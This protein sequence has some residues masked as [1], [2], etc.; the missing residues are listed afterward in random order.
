MRV[1]KGYRGSVPCARRRFRL[2]F[3]VFHAYGDVPRAVQKR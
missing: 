3:V 1:E 2:D